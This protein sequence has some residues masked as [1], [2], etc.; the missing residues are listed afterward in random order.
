MS[1][2][3][4]ELRECRD[5]VA[6]VVQNFRLSKGERATAHDLTFLIEVKKRRGEAL[7]DGWVVID[8]DHVV[9]LCGGYQFPPISRTGLQRWLRRTGYGQAEEPD[10]IRA[11]VRELLSWYFHPNLGALWQEFV[12]GGTAA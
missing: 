12:T 3:V 11:E 6:G 8:E 2:D 4:A 9:A 5:G 7:P 10:L 1:L